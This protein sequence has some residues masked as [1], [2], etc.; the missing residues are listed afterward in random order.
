LE[1]DVHLFLLF[2]R[3]CM[4]QKNLKILK[5]QKTPSRNTHVRSGSLLQVALTPTGQQK[6]LNFFYGAANPGEFP[7]LDSNPGLGSSQ[8]RRGIF[9]EAT[10][11]D[12]VHP[13]VRS[14]FLISFQEAFQL[15]VQADSVR[16][17]FSSPLPHLSSLLSAN[18]QSTIPHLKEE[19]G[20]REGR[21]REPAERRTGKVE[22]G[23]RERREE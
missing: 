17:F 14:M 12:S 20:M 2:N 15:K 7:E 18:T 5:I 9:F 1:K 22:G 8:K 23:D 13:H 19:G 10:D 16:L 21:R 6:V 4:L 3:L 11:I